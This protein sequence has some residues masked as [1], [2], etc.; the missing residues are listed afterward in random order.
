LDQKV[1][2]DR[3]ALWSGKI[4][5]KGK[6]GGEPVWRG[7]PPATGAEILLSGEMLI[8]GFSRGRR[9]SF[10]LK[11]AMNCSTKRIGMK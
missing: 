3:Q 7:E 10:I 9:A 2:K 11:L 5:F 8:I 1:T 6:T 4:R